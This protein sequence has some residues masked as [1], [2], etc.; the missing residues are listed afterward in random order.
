MAKNYNGTWVETEQGFCVKIR[1]YTVSPIT[2]VF[3]FISEDGMSDSI[4]S[5]YDISG[6]FDSI[7][8]KSKSNQTKIASTDSELLRNKS[9]WKFWK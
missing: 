7:I 1:S 8:E 6:S 2:K 5:F 3:K 9:W 4:S